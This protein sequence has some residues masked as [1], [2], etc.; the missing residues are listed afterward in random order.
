[1][2]TPVESVFRSGTAHMARPLPPSRWNLPSPR[3][4]T[5]GEDVVA[6]GGELDP[7]TVL[8]AYASGMFPMHLHDG[9]A[10]EQVLAWWSPDPRGVLP[11]DHLR[12]SRSLRKSMNHFTFTLDQAFDRV[13]THCANPARGHG[14]INHDIITCYT[15][16]HRSGWAH[17][18]EVWNQRAELVGGLYGVEVGGLFAGESMFHLERDASKAALVHLVSVLRACEGPRILDVQWATAHLVSLGVVEIPRHAYLD[19][20]ANVVPLEPCLGAAMQR[21]APR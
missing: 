8:H 3:E 12:V 20:I 19:L 16:L 9:D 1:M 18:V 14:W 15:E 17:S 21:R 4:A 7:G 2:S 6:T 11:L 13:M 10:G 5:A